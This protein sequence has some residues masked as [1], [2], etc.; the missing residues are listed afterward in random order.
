MS[1]HNVTPGVAFV[2]P[3][4]A[5]PV[6]PGESEIP[7]T[8]AAL[9]AAAR[10]SRDMGAAH[11]QRQGARASFRKVQEL[12]SESDKLPLDKEGICDIGER[13]LNRFAAMMTSA[14]RFAAVT[15]QETVSVTRG[16]KVVQAFL[17]R[18]DSRHFVQ[19]RSTAPPDDGVASV[20]VTRWL[21]GHL[22]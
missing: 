17:Q 7:V 1:G 12:L 15:P 6:G 19:Q 5:R 10:S 4:Q 22:M 13:Q 9:A 2:M 11:A 14:V 8:V 3:A 18:K 21:T 16:Q 20:A